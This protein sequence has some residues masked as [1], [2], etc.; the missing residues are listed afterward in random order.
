MTAETRAK[1]GAD[2]RTGLEQVYLLHQASLLRFLRA[3]GAGDAAEDLLQELWIKASTGVSGPVNDPLPYLY[4]AANNL[5]LDRHRA[6]T[7]RAR[8]E[9]DWSAIAGT[10]GGGASGEPSPERSLIDQG[11]LR[12]AQAMLDS[13]GERTV[14]IFRRFRLEG[15][16]QRQIAADEGISVSAVEKH[17]QKAYRLLLDIRRR[18][19]AD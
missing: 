9:Q 5:M 16:S 19:D 1:A 15:E 10:K 18:H 14:K 6:E 7:R 3:R 4:R 12:A 17:L 13:L 2:S 11:E 8:R